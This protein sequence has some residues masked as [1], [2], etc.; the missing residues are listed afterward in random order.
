MN[1]VRPY[2]PIKNRDVACDTLKLI[3]MLFIAIFHCLQR[4]GATSY[5]SGL[6][7]SL[8]YSVALAM[9]FFAGGMLIKRCNNLKDLG[10]YIGKTLITYLVP[11]YL[12]TCLSIWA[13]PRFTLFEKPFSFWMNELYLRTDTFYWFFLVAA[14]INIFIAIIYYLTTLVKN[15][16]LWMD[17][18]KAAFLIGMSCGYLMVF[19]F[20]YNQPD[21]GPGCLSANMVLY[22]YPISLLAFLFAMFRGYLTKLRHL[23]VYAFALF[24]GCLGAYIIL[25]LRYSDWLPGLKGDFWEITGHAICSFCGVVSYFYIFKLIA[26]YRFVDRISNLGSYS[27]PFYLV[28]VYIVRLLTSYIARGDINDR[29]YGSFVVFLTIC[30]VSGSLLITM[31]LCIIPYSDLLLFGNVR[32]IKDALNPRKWFVREIRYCAGDKAAD[33]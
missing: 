2:R 24:L 16:A 6:G 31:F 19:L 25:L 29:T 23:K 18:L 4:W 9:F 27:G 30:F 15:K 21:L 7:F 1:F 33:V 20:I 12:F 13:L 14:F 5:V 10:I 22:Y 32:R 17:I 3:S 26:K 11:A 28:H 8:F